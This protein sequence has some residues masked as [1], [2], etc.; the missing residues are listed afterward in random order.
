MRNAGQEVRKGEETSFRARK[1]MRGKFHGFLHIKKKEGM[2]RSKKQ[3]LRLEL[4]E[5]NFHIVREGKDESMFNRRNVKM[6][7]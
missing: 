7:M 5:H 1:T 4:E 6:F 3:G 2:D